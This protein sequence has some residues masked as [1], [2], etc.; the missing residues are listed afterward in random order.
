MA[1]GPKE[2]GYKR[3]Q[4][5]QFVQRKTTTDRRLRKKS[6][7]YHENMYLKMDGKEIPESR[8][9]KKQEYPVSPM[10]LLVLLFLVV[11]SSV[12]GMLNTFQ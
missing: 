7:A 5:G 3:P 11:G 12:F 8:R 1:E 6:D 10:L 4:K 2:E 9:L